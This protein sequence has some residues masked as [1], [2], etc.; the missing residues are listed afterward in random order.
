[1]SFEV[2][3]RFRRFS[4]SAL[5]AAAALINSH[6]VF[7]QGDI[8][9]SLRGAITDKT[10]AA[11]SG[12]TATMLNN[13]TGSRYTA[14][15]SAQGEYTFSSVPPGTY[16]LLVDANGFAESKFDH[17]VINLNQIETLP[18]TL[19]VSGAQ[20]TV[21]VSTETENIVTQ[22]TSVTG[23][24][25]QREIANLPMNG[26]DYQNLVYLSPGVTR[27]A[28]GT[29]QGS[30][31]VA[32]GTRPTDNNYMIDGADNND[33]VV[34]SGA[35]GGAGGQ[36]GAVPID[37][38]AEFT[39][40][41]ANGAAEFGRSSGAIINVVTRSGTNQVHGTLFEFVRNPKF[42]TRQW[43]DPIGFKSAFKQNDFGGR[44]GLP[45]RR[46]KTFMAGAYE[47]YRQRQ[48]YTSTLFYPSAQ[49]INTITDPALKAM[50]LAFFPQTSNGGTAITSA[51]YSQTGVGVLTSTRKLTN[52]LDGDTGFVRF[53]QNFSDKHQAFLTGS[54][55]DGV[56]G[57]A[58]SA[59]TPYSGYGETLRPYHFVLGDNYAVTPNV[60]NTARIAFQR[61]AYAF[62]GETPPAAVLNSGTAR[63]AGPYAGQPYSAS[64]A[65]AN[66]VPTIAS[67]NGLFGTMGTA[68]NFP[69]G[70]AANT[71]V[72]S[73]ALSWQKGKHQFKFGAELRRIQENGYFSNDVRPA[74]TI[75]DSSLANLD[76]GL[77]TSQAQY[78]Y[79]TG[80]SNRGF[81]QLEQGYFAEDSWR[82][83]DRLTVEYGIRYEIFPAFGESRNLIN[84]AFVMDSNNNPQR[85]ASLPVGT[86][87]MSSIALLNPTSYGF[88]AF[89]TDYNNIAPRVGFA[90]DIAGNGKTVLRGGWGYYYDRLFD[91]VYGNSRFNAP[92]VAPITLTS[93]VYDGTQ[94]VG[95]ISTSTVYT[96]TIIDPHLRTPYT[97]HFN[98]AVSRELDR[99]TSLTVGYVGSVGTK[100]LTTLNP[101][102]GTSFPDAF[103]PTN[104]PIAAANNGSL[105]RSQA[106]IN[107]GIIRGPFGNLS[108]RESNGTSNF[109]SLEVTLK[110][111]MSFGLSGQAA[112]T[113]AHSMDSMSDD[114]SGNTDSASPQSTVD[115][116]LA[117]YL[118]PGSPCSTS[119][120][121]AANLTASTI[122]S[123]T[124]HLGAMQCATGNTSLTAATAPNAFVANDV[125]YRPIGSNYGDSAFDVRQRLAVHLVYELP[126]GHGRMLANNASGVVDGVIGG[127]NISSAIDTQT[128]TPF[129]ITTGVDS[130]RD[131]TTNDRVRVLSYS[132]RTPGLVKNSSVYGYPASGP[133]VSMLQCSSTAVDATT[134]S[135]T[136]T[137]GSGTI[138]FNQ[139]IGLLDPTIRMHRGFLRE[140]G[141]FNWDMQLAKS[142]KMYHESSLRC[143]ADCFN[144]LN[145]A[146]FGVLGNTLTSSSLARASS[147]RSINNTASRQFQLALKYEF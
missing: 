66:G 28:S 115:N 55:L 57:A 122:T 17:V 47:G 19:A 111:R 104:A 98:M 93:G 15:V 40:I 67:L 76:Q 3:G 16:T 82:A 123:A 118:A 56:Y 141:I 18:V 63:T 74:V 14:T 39:V 142:V 116:L 73:D 50:M 83:T 147:Q 136:C 38:I 68:S 60:A 79:L 24:F 4:I 37:E 106:D 86:A 71:I 139:G 131:G 13:E 101:N 108:Y 26:R 64:L 59:V 130:N 62:P 25:T 48:T 112:Y 61:T 46:N 88:K 84:N 31:V 91:N 81:R 99:N 43:F 89:C 5:L 45:L 107:A 10:G 144:V 140:P 146:N 127:W 90:Y 134:R 105:V 54:I 36:I 77:Y 97:Q 72:E 21:E 2:P 9:G 126:F 96:G 42:N 121:A 44:F 29:G 102:F 119:Q 128:G 1:M 137:S 33:P 125:K 7:A 94:A 109:H 22:E 124:T 92:Q 52:N 75:N 114:I 85:C 27:S 51:N 110:R 11:I 132:D 78:F 69:Q 65:S 8:G 117:P 20:T 87:A 129:I 32:A 12:G 120:V 143:S 95:A 41:S 103:R 80:S 34:P 113:W 49:L 145:H 100:L 135:K 6:P 23:L 133:N 138:T 58:N 35:A 30:G 53:D 70:R